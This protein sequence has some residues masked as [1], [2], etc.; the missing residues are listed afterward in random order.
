MNSFPTSQARA[1]G[2][3]TVRAVAVVVMGMRESIT[4]DRVV[5]RNRAVL[6]LGMVLAS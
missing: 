6:A 5:A 3:A 1:H 4:A 2:G